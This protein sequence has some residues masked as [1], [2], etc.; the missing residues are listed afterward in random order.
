MYTCRLPKIELCQTVKTDN[1]N[2]VLC[3]LE[4]ANG[5][6]P[7][8]IPLFPS[9]GKQGVIKAR[10]KR[11]FR[12]NGAADVVASFNADAHDIPLDWEHASEIKAPFGEKAPAAGW[13]TKLSLE[14]DGSIVGDVEWTAAGQ[15]SVE[16]REY[17]YISP[18]FKLHPDTREVQQIVSAGL[19]NTP[20]LT[21]PALTSVQSGDQMNPK[22]LKLLG[23]DDKATPEQV[24][25]AVEAYE[26]KI[27]ADAAAKTTLEATSSKLETELA[28]ARGTQPDIKQFVPRAD[29]DATLARVVVLE[30][31]AEDEKAAAHKA[32]VDTEIA[33]AMQAGKIAPASKDYFAKSCATVEGLAAFREYC[34]SAPVIAADSGLGTKPTPTSTPEAGLTELD[35]QVAERCGMSREALIASVKAAS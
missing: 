3:K 24:D 17:R 22:I 4:L 13:I 5:K 29:Y 7:S 8:R 12:L 10:D 21:M 15:Q 28:A 34:G 32:Q 19:T 14:S 11:V 18:A 35:F 23:L 27:A 26:A 25:A 9:P 30:K 16:S 31:N 2:T 6:A 33:V 1:R 20:A